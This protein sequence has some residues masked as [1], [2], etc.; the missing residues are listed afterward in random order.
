MDS[1]LTLKNYSMY[2]F[3]VYLCVWLYILI[4][5]GLIIRGNVIVLYFAHKQHNYLPMYKIKDYITFS[6]LLDPA[7][8]SFLFMPLLPSNPIWHQ[9]SLR[10]CFYYE[11]FFMR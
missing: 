5:K 8:F 6:L 9:L 2:V 10:E 11:G 4:N 1:I 3:L 7:L